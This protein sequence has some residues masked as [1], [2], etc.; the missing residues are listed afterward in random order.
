MVKHEFNNFGFTKT[1]V[2]EYIL[3]Y[4]KD[5]ANDISQITENSSGVSSIVGPGTITHYNFK[6]SNPLKEYV[7]NECLVYLQTF[8]SAVEYKLRSDGV[9]SENRQLC[10]M[11]PWINIQ[12]QTEWLPPH[13]HTGFI[14]FTIWISLP[15]ESTFEFIYSTITGDKVKCPLKLTKENEGEMI[16][17]P[18]KIMHCVHPFFNSDETRIT[19]AGNIGITSVE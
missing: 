15:E 14:S 17:F 3:S 16:M 2:P 11:N 5:E 4:I 9:C 1:K 7:S 6:N 8:Y 13:D 10:V 12:K 18:S 19:V